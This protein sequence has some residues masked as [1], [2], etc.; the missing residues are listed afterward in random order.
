MENNPCEAVKNNVGGTRTV[1]EISRLYGVERFVLI[2]TDKAANPSSI[3]GATKRVAEMIVQSMS[4]GTATRFVAVRFGNVLGSNGSVIPRM[5]EQIRT[6]GP[7]T[8]THPE[9][10]RYFM[11][12]PEAVELVLQAAVLARGRETFVLDMGE[13]M[14]IVDMAKNL[15]RLSGFVPDVQ[16]PIKF[17]GLRPGEKLVEELVGEGETLEPSEV[18]KIFRVGWHHTD[19]ARL[20]EQV[21]SAVSHAKQGREAETIAHLLAIV[22]TFTRP[23]GTH[24]E[25]G[26]RAPAGMGRPLPHSPV[27]IQ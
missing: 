15:I 2:S 4:E 23:V 5:V 9:I 21:E 19:A 18:P 14:R 3:M 12:I 24:A 22:P 10:R 16:I 26:D 13:Q 11:L 6:G 1:A 17:V 25:T 27:P 7:V 8:V 20:R